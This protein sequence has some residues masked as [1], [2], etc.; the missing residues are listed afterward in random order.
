MATSAGLTSS[1]DEAQAKLNENNNAITKYMQKR[2]AVG[3]EVEMLEAKGD[4]LNTELQHRLIDLRQTK[5]AHELTI[6]SLKNNTQSLEHNVDLRN[7]YL[8]E[9]KVNFSNHQRQVQSTFTQKDLDYL[10]G[11]SMSTLTTGEKIEYSQ[12]AGGVQKLTEM[13]GLI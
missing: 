5:M 6:N 9:A 3:R 10:A 8:T 7:H 12:K 2:D 11:K 4:N 13:I 1:L